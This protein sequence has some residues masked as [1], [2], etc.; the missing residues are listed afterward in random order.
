MNRRKELIWILIGVFTII[1]AIIAVF[2]YQQVKGFAYLTIKVAPADL[3]YTIGSTT[4]SGDQ[5]DVKVPAGKYKVTFQHDLY[6]TQNLDIQLSKNEK[7]TLAIVLKLE[8]GVDKQYYSLGVDERSQ[9]DAYYD[10]SNE[11]NMNA[12]ISSNPVV[13]VL[14]QITDEYRIDYGFDKN[15]TLYYE[16]TLYKNAPG[17]NKNS[18]LSKAKNWIKEQGYNPEVL[19]LK[20]TEE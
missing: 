6:E 18:T 7:K 8:D 14:P 17:Y 10:K 9:I 16:I 11:I 19:P 1:C 20:I 4:L 12:F 5:Q 15:K 2:T 13:K 3:K